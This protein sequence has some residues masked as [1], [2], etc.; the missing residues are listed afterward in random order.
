MLQNGDS[1]WSSQCMLSWT[2]WNRAIEFLQQRVTKGRLCAQHR[3]TAYK[4]WV[5]QFIFLWHLG[6]S[7]NTPSASLIKNVKCLFQKAASK[8]TFFAEVA[9]ASLCQWKGVPLQV[10]IL[11]L[12][13]LC[14]HY[15]SLALLLVNSCW[16]QA[17][18]ECPPLSGF[19]EFLVWRDPKEPTQPQQN[20]HLCLHH[21][22][23]SAATS[24][25][26]YKPK[27]TPLYTISSLTLKH[28]SKVGWA[29]QVL[30]MD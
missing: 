18:S 20:P 3:K 9:G 5:L 2:F 26:T 21:P 27:S 14:L 29:L 24:L 19:R 6:E 16:R 12:F 13:C 10:E 25:M 15:R 7:E 4:L 11:N 22:Y 8:Y 30:Q 17:S 23:V 1:Q 28:F